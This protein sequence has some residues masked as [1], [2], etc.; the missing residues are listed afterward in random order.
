MGGLAPH[1]V[2]RT[3]TIFGADAIG[4]GQDLGSIEPGKMADIL[5]LDRDPLADLRNTTSLRYVMK[6]GRLYD[7][8]TLDEMWPRERKLAAQPWQD[9]GMGGVKAGVR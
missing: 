4:M 9:G 5:V 2:L 8:N 1:D 6:N 3:A 7:A